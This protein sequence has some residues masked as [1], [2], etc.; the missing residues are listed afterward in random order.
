M[1]LS[2]LYSG[3]ELIL[4]K[5][6][7]INIL[8]CYDVFASD[9]FCEHLPPQTLEEEFCLN[10]VD[11]I[12]NGK[13]E[14]FRDFYLQELELRKKKKALI[15][16]LSQAARNVEFER[17]DYLESSKFSICF[18]E[19][20]ASVCTLSDSDILGICNS[21]TPC[22]VDNPDSY[23][24]SGNEASSFD[25]FK[26]KLTPLL[27]D[28]SKSYFEKLIV[29]EEEVR[30]II[31]QIIG[32]INKEVVFGIRKSDLFKQEDLERRLRKLE[33]K[34]EDMYLFLFPEESIDSARKQI[35]ITDE[36]LFFDVCGETGLGINA[37]FTPTFNSI[38]VCPGIYLE[39]L[40]K[41]RDGFTPQ[42][43][44]NLFIRLKQVLAH[45]LEHFYED[46]FMNDNI[47]S[48][49]FRKSLV[50]DKY[51]QCMKK[52]YVLDSKVQVNI[53]SY[54]DELDAYINGIEVLSG[55]LKEGEIISNI[56]L[57]RSSLG[58]MCAGHSFNVA[59]RS[60][61][62]PLFFIEQMVSKHPAIYKAFNCS[63]Y[64]KDVLVVGCDLEGETILRLGSR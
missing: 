37:Y 15:Q 1:R 47:F 55:Q 22:F 7:L 57:L 42:V 21:E 35:N 44:K 43:K 27:D 38:T 64:E 26:R 13:T 41:N 31:W 62:S 14:S 8:C 50:S 11:V 30:E 40:P 36:S 16:R 61:P 59:G 2:S 24:L 53:D 32:Q 20:G 9:Q 45:E 48:D 18:P 23:Y 4:I 51:I 28:Y 46:I 5:L 17:S 34:I 54:R 25:S 19:E 49:G 39:L 56:K 3:V 52:N 58:I 12:C 6:F 33:E 63:Q 10:P 29:D 60:H